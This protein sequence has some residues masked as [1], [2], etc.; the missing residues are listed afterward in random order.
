MNTGSFIAAGRRA[1][2]RLHDSHPLERTAVGGRTTYLW[3]VCEH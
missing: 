2:V 1:G 3:P